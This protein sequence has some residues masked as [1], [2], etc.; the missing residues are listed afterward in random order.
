MLSPTPESLKPDEHSHWAASPCWAP[1]SYFGGCKDHPHRTDLSCC[2]IRRAD[3][4][5]LTT[6]DTWEEIQRLRTA[7]R[8]CLDGIDYTVRVDAILRPDER[9][10]GLE[11]LDRHRS[12]LPNTGDQPRADDGLPPK[13]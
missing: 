3:G 4:S 5:P 11:K 2:K 6:A 10:I 12:L 13:K 9:H 8:E 7:L 1:S